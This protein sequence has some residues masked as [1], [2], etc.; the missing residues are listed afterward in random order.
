MDKGKFI[1]FKEDIALKVVF[2]FVFVLNKPLLWKKFSFT[3]AA[4]IVQKVPISPLPVFPLFKSRNYCNSFLFLF[5][6]FCI[7]A[8]ST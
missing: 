7:V 3:E 4:K 6:F 8:K 2:Y 5:L 1:Q